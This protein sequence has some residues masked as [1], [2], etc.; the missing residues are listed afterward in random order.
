MGYFP[1]WAGGCLLS[2]INAT[3]PLTRPN[4]GKGLGDI[5]QGKKPDSCRKVSAFLEKR[6]WER[7]AEGVAGA[8]GGAEGE[9]RRRNQQSISTTQSFP[10][11]EEERRQRQERRIPPLGRIC[12]CLQFLRG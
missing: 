11:V 6:E 12:H 1:S 4:S 10:E 2:T 7:Q 5:L 9:A 8:G 3:S